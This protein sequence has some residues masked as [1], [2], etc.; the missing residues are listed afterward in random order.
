VLGQQQRDR[1]AQDG[2]LAYD[3]PLLS[4]VEVEAV[5]RRILE[6]ASGEVPGL[7]EE[8]FREER[9]VA[10]DPARG[11]DGAD[12]YRVIRYLHKYD[13]LIASVCRSPRIL[14]V[15]EDLLGPDIKL[16]TDQV[17]MKPPFHGSAQAWHQDSGAWPFFLP[18]SHITCWIAID[19][20][21]AENGCLRYLPGT[22]TLGLV[23]RAHV[24]VLVDQLQA[25]AVPVPRRPGFGVF[26][27]SLLLHSSGPNTTPNRRRGLVL[28][29][30]SAET[31]YI[32]LEGEWR[33]P[34]QLMRGREFP[35]RV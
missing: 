34:F 30:V 16:Y 18:H 13:D 4:P 35:G 28:H 26:H 11:L 6:I 14:D 24:P 9:G 1:Y 29:Y 27:H 3:E 7:P 23:D 31:R 17:F 12:R 10:A 8:V 2:Y 19:E 33:G 21:T 5:G 15:V 32:G 25:E 20:A 22:H